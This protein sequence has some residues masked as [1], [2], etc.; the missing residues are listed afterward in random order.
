MR[1]FSCAEPVGPIIIGL[2]SSDI[3]K[4]WR[5]LS[6]SLVNRTE[7]GPPHAHWAIVGSAGASIECIP[8]ES[9]YAI[10]WLSPSSI[11]NRMRPVDTW[12][13]AEAAVDAGD[14]E[15]PFVQA[16]KARMAKRVIG[17]IRARRDGRPPRGCLEPSIDVLL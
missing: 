12:G 3:V 17:A 14:E 15:P 10:E 6:R 8:V 9:M 1:G 16:V 2:P 11:P 13:P 4:A 7:P 5:T